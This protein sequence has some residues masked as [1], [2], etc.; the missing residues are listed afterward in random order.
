MK[1]LL[2]NT[3]VYAIIYATQVLKNVQNGNRS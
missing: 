2:T 3:A 1:L